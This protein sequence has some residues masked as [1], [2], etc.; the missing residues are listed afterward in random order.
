MKVKN[1]DEAIAV[2]RSSLNAISGKNMH[3]ASHEKV[4]DYADHLARKIKE[5]LAVEPSCTPSS[6]LSDV[7]WSI[8]DS[9]V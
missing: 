5:E 9:A 2:A 8:M 7:A 6:T 1:F 3:I 4:G